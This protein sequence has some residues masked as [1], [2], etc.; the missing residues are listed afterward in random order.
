VE[1]L[2]HVKLDLF[3]DEVYVFT[4]RGQILVLPKQATVIDF[5]YAVHTDVGNHCV[6]ARIDR[7]FAPLH[8]RLRSGQTVEI[9][10]APA[11][12]PNPAWLDFVVTSKA[13]ANIRAFLKQLQQREAIDLGRRLLEKELEGHGRVLAT[14]PE[15]ELAATLAQ[16]NL[17]SRDELYEEIGLGNR[18]PLLVALRLAGE[19]SARTP[20][21]RD[22]P[23]GPL[24]IRGT[25]GMVVKFAKCCRPIPGD[26]VIALFNRGK[27]LVVHHQACHNLAEFRRGG[28]TWLDV[29]WADGVEGEFPTEIKVE[30]GNQRGVLA[31]VAAAIAE[32][33]SNIESVRS[34]ERDGLTSTLRF[35]IN[36]RGRQHLARILR[37]LRLVPAVMRITRVIG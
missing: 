35:V 8:S 36:V 5:A 34:E 33:G 13:R 20:T 18:M 3:P 25:E 28:N 14:I 24:A 17:R 4:P 19:D 16:L 26:P 2:E 11:A 12:H 37:R 32:Q 29:R 9:V 21:L 1:F 27:G 22:K 7:R 23:A 15:E 31:T 30:A 6:G 10:T